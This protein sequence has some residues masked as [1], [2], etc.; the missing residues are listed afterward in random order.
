M[1]DFNV[2]KWLVF[3][4]H[5]DAIKWKIAEN[6]EIS[7]DSETAD[8]ELKKGR[9]RHCW[10]TYH[11]F[12][13]CMWSGVLRWFSGD[14]WKVN[15][16]CMFS[17]IQ[18]IIVSAL[19]MSQKDVCVSFYTASRSWTVTVKAHIIRC[20][21]RCNDYY[22]RLSFSSCWWEPVISTV[23]NL[24]NIVIYFLSDSHSTIQDSFDLIWWCW[25]KI[26]AQGDKRASTG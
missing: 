25:Q 10:W 8:T 12:I 19:G 1:T 17:R 16:C 6:V 11:T 23:V 5:D 7:K 26:P 20:C 4:S 18:R 13:L 9:A 15:W 2:C 14:P 3:L 22:G 24:L 21:K